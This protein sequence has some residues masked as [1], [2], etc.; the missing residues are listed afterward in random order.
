M[1][2]FI[3]RS[4]KSEEFNPTKIVDSIERANADVEEPERIDKKML[5]DLTNSFV[6]SK[7][8]KRR[9]L[10]EDVKDEMVIALVGAGKAKLA[11]AYYNNCINTNGIGMS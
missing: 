3:K 6:A 7:R 5:E 2:Q 10:A 4:G 9:V 8:R 11:S 1:K